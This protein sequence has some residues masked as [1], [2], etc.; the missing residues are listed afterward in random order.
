MK[1]TR[2]AK[3]SSKTV[4][5]A[6]WESIWT[7]YTAAVRSGDAEQLSSARAEVRAWHDRAGAPIPAYAF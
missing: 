5:A 4:L 1:T 6:S 7:R 2:T 3:A